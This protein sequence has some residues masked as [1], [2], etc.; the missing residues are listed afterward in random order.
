MMSSAW[1]SV[2]AKIRVFGTSLRPGKISGSLSRKVRMTV[3]IWSGLTISRSSCVARIV[4]VLVLSSP[5]ASC[6]VS[7]SRFSTCCSALSVRALPGALGFDD[8][9]LVADIHAV[10][11][12]LLMAVFADDVLVEEA[13][14]AVVRRRRQADQIGVEILDHLPPEI[15]DRAVA[16]IDDDEVEE[17]RRNFL[18]VDDRQ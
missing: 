15:V 1:L 17:L 4:L 10:G 12:G 5:S 14:G 7:R 2:L 6:G 16:F 3:R 8:I 9:D 18:V 11:D 13:V